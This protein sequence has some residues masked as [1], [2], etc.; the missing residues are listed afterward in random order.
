MGRAE[1]NAYGSAG[2]NNHFRSLYSY[3]PE[4]LELGIAQ[5]ERALAGD[6]RVVAEDRAYYML[7]E[8]LLQAGVD[9]RPVIEEALRQF[10]GDLPLRTVGVLA[11]N[12]EICVSEESEPCLPGFANTGTVALTPASASPETYKVFATAYH[13]VGKRF[14]RQR[15][16]RRAAVFLATSIRACE[17]GY[18]DSTYSYLSVK[19]ALF[20]L[21]ASHVMNDQADRA[22]EIYAEILESEP[23]NSVA[24]YNIAL[25]YYLS[26]RRDLFGE[27]RA[28]LAEV[29]RG[30]A[31]ALESLVAPGVGNVELGLV[32]PGYRY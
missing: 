20:G 30:M 23:Q 27:H 8:M 10:P 24:R 25:L 19:D 7:V 16:Y 14:L 21:A 12:R 31:G 1:A 2:Y 15:D 6:G 32:L 11:G 5:L 3:Q 22:S 17:L 18:S 26:D 29:D 9:P 13:R 28:L 4:Y